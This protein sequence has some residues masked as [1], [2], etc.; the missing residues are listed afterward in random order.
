MLEL[1]RL[2]AQLEV[3]PEE[4][5]AICFPFGQAASP[6][7]VPLLPERRL[8]SWWTE[9]VEPLAERQRQ[10]S[11]ASVWTPEEWAEQLASSL[12]HLAQRHRGSLAA[13]ARRWGFPKDR[14][15]RSL[16]GL[17]SLSCEEVFAV[18]AQVGVSPGRFLFELALPEAGLADRLA[19]KR[20]LDQAEELLRNAEAGVERAGKG[21]AG[22]KN[23]APAS[24]ES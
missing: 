16:R 15:G 14:L 8:P 4:V 10:Q 13:A 24:G 5:F 1:F 23:G 7:G 18:L 2:L 21:R 12:R 11:L 3:K 6:E 20:L 22:G 9:L 19:R 17:H